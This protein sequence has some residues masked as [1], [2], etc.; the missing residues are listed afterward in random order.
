MPER[1]RLLLF[2]P[3]SAGH[4]GEYI[5]YLLRA[6]PGAAGQLH[7]SVSA[8]LLEKH[9]DLVELAAASAGSITLETLADGPEVERLVA[10]SLV[11]AGRLQG[12]LF[13]SVLERHRPHHALAMYVDH[14]LPSL[15]L[16][17]RVPRDVRV[18]GILFRPSFHYASTPSGWGERLRDLRKRLMLRAALQHPRLD[19][20]F[21]LDPTAVEPLQRLRGAVHVT[22]LPD[23]VPAR[24]PALTRP[25]L[26]RP[27]QA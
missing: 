1:P 7:V 12:R 15:A 4:H 19:R 6:W 14:L 13:A 24:R 9:P 3:Y 10:V 5:R 11:Q 18:S 2:D 20:L 16:R 23:P 8:T 21:S 27:A 17:L 22:A 26:T 25:A